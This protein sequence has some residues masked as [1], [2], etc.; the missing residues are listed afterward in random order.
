MEKPTH[1]FY[2]ASA[3]QWATTNEERN[4]RDLIKLMDADKISYALWLVPVTW[5]TAY[6]INFYAPQVEGSQMIEFFTF[7]NGRKA[8]A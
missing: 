4:L 1:H 8:K 2:A 3:Y 7:K 6:G 5:N